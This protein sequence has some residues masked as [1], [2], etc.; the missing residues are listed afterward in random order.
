MNSEI[1]IYHYIIYQLIQQKCNTNH[2]AYDYQQYMWMSINYIIINLAV[3]PH[4]H[5]LLYIFPSFLLW[6][7]LR[8]PHKNNVWFVLSLVV[9]RRAQVLFTLFLCLFAHSGIQHILCS[10]FVFLRVVCLVFPVSLD[11]PFLIV[12]S[13]FSNVSLFLDN[14]CIRG[15]IESRG[16][17]LTLCMHYWYGLANC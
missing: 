5:G 10:C 2:L 12:H 4:W 17:Y 9:C 13:V 6:C 7:P 16:C 1:P 11:C 3:F 8:L 14:T 15:L